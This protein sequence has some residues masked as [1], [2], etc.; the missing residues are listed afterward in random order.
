MSGSLL[1]TSNASAAAQQS[2]N[3]AIDASAA[4]SLSS[5]STGSAANALNSLTSNFNDFLQLLM[6]QL[7]NQ[8][9]TAP[10]DST[11]FTAELVQFAGVQQQV[12][13][14]SNLQQLI[15]LTQ[16]EETLQ[17]SAMVGKS[18]DLNATTLPLQNGTGTIDYTAIAANE[19]VQITITDNAGKEVR[20]VNVDSSQKGTNSWTWNGQNDSGSQVPDGVYNVGVQGGVGQS[21]SAMPFTVM[22]TVTG[23]I[24]NSGTIALQ[25]G[26]L[27]TPLSSIAS[28]TGN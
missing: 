17:G 13:T 8:D 12:D 28:V 3:S 23:V 7:Q 25:V 9:P 15:E 2:V 16:G 20:T 10:M 27:T 4:S 21:V 11:Q 24:S 5:A 19:A 14:N 1:S 26:S 22:G 6:T 18:V